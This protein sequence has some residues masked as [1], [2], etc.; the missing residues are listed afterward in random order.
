MALY[1]YT[2]ASGLI[3]ILENK[4][5]WV[6]D[7]NYM[8]DTHEIKHGLK[9]I[10]DRFSTNQ[11]EKSLITVQFLDLLLSNINQI[12]TFL[13][14]SFCKSGNIL[15]MWRGY[16]S[17]GQKYALQFNEASI[18]ASMR[19]QYPTADIDFYDC[20]Y[21][22]GDTNQLAQ[23]ACAQWLAD[24]EAMVINEQG[25]MVINIPKAIKVIVKPALIMKNYGF[26]SEDER[27]L[28]A[29]MGADFVDYR[30]RAGAYGITPYVTLDFDLNAIESIT[31]GP[32]Q[33]EFGEMKSIFS[34]LRKMGKVRPFPENFVT[35]SDIT[36]R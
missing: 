31:I 3:G 12:G 11:D 34:I 29:L 33:N 17:S 16:G 8:N 27:R 23:E 1:H 4:T 9:V 30:H 26:E 5:L 22:E 7:V 10:R 35:V 6:N 20:V 18:L 21:G 28:L 15:D 14:T 32:T 36:F 2:D 25:N 13:I 19:E 24:E